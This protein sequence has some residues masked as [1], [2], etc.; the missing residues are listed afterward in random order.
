[1][2]LWI[3]PTFFHPKRIPGLWG[4]IIHAVGYSKGPR[5]RNLGFSPEPW[6]REKGR[7]KSKTLEIANKVNDN[8]GAGGTPRTRGAA[9]GLRDAAASSR[10]WPGMRIAVPGDGGRAVVAAETVGEWEHPWLCCETPS[11]CLCLSGP[12]TRCVVVYGQVLKVFGTEEPFVA[13]LG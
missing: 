7:E 6:C 3:N 13:G 12:P 8:P 9:A 10:W 2:V 5:C 11:G 1:M 4:Y